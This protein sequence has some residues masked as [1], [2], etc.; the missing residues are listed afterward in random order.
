MGNLTN[1][2]INGIRTAGL[3]VNEASPVDDR[4]LVKDVA[5]VLGGMPSANAVV[6]DL[7]LSL[8]DGMVIQIRGTRKEYVWAESEYGI[9]DGG[10]T[11]PAWATDIAGQN[12]A[13][14]KYN[15]V[16]FDKV[17]KFEVIY[18]SA[19]MPLG[20]L[21]PYK[22]LPF[23]VL[24]DLGNANVT[25]KS[26]ASNFEEIEHPDKLRIYPAGLTVLMDPNPVNGEVFKITIT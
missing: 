1:Q 9:V 20:I 14:K 5:A 3:Q 21:L 22:E 13:N 4:L 17:S 6:T 12:Y 10:Y 25:M 8:Y 18:N 26:S 7:I 24:Q 11:Y 16:L 19:S 15:F 23:H 2:Y